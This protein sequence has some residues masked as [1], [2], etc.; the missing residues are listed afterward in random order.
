MI[1]GANRSLESVP[2]APSGPG[3]TLRWSCMGCGQSRSLE[4]AKGQGLRKRC[5][6]C[7]Q[8]KAGRAAT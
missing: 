5:A 2:R 1:G 6:V 4:G 3:M 7:V 8:A